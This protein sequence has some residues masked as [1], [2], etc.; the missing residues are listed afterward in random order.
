MN[1]NELWDDLGSLEDDQALLILSQLFDLY[2]K[3]IKQD[4]QDQEAVQFFNYL[5][6]V[7]SQVQT[8]NVNRR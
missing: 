2:E 1:V 4:P 6:S 7:M 5:Q 3:K 8:C